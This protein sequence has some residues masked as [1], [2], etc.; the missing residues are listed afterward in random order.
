MILEHGRKTLSTV[1]AVG[2]LAG[3]LSTTSCSPSS[4]SANDGEITDAKAKNAAREMIL[5]AG[6]D[7]PSIG[8]VFVTGETP[9]GTQMEVLCGFGDGSDKIDVNLHY[10]IYPDRGIVHV[11]QPWSAFGPKCS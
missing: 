7:C 2:F 8:T 6:F 4:K 5:S 3:V 9:I 11:C 10:A 1:A